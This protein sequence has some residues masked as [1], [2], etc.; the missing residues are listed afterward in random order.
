MTLT[1]VMNGD[2]E[3]A[4]EPQAAARRALVDAAKGAAAAIGFE[5]VDG[6]PRTANIARRGA[7]SWTLRSTGTPA[8]SSQIFHDDVGAGAIFE[9]AR[10]LDAF[11]ARLAGREHLT[12]N[13]GVALGGTAVTL[14]AP[15]NQGGASGK[16][17]VVAK[18]AVVQGDLRALTP[19]QLAATKIAGSSCFFRRLT[20]ISSDSGRS[21]GRHARPDPSEPGRR[22]PAPG[23]PPVQRPVPGGQAPSG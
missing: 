17:N 13:P 15:E 11:R 2:E 7:A 16:T 1:V 20:D 18:E 21:A 19:E 8:H 5:D 10:V 12:F 22:A 6:D 14:D 4:G 3:H 23:R 9:A